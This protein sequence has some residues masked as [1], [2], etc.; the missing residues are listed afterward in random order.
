LSNGKCSRPGGDQGSP[1]LAAGRLARRRATLA[2]PG[3]A[4]VVGLGLDFTP[5]GDDFLAG[6]LLAEA[7]LP[8][9][10]R[11]LDRAAIARALGGTHPR[12]RTLLALA[13]R[14]SFRRYLPRVLDGLAASASQADADAAV[15]E[16]AAHGETP[17]TNT[18]VGLLWRCG[19]PTA[20]S[21]S[22]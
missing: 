14:G 1:R 20:R 9:G 22:G 8:G 4:A 2:G 7:R 11:A 10:G 17:G 3:A 18:M 5:S 13:R 21:G 6:A 12:G 16:A 15:V 19:G